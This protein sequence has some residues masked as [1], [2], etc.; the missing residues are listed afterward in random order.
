MQCNQLCPKKGNK[1][2]RALEHKSDV[3][4]DCSEEK[5][6]G[7][8]YRSLQRPDRRLWQGGGQSLLPETNRD[9]M[10]G[11]GLKW[12]QEKFRL[13]IRTDFFSKRAVKHWHR[14]PREV[15]Q[16]RNCGDVALRD[17]VS[18]YGGMG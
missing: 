5:A 1:A 8:P 9:R 16:F 18:E 7:R 10:R 13:D 3:N 15:V 6:Q 14:L 12:C 17:V 11:N 2:V 4:W